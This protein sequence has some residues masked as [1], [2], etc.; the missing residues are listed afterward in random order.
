M[1]I[2]HRFLVCDYCHRRVRDDKPRE[3]W[4]VTRRI[5]RCPEHRDEPVAV[6]MTDGGFVEYAIDWCEED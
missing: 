1:R 5:V 4:L 6:T 2:H 3:G